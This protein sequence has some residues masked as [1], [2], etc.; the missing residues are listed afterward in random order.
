MPE[1]SPVFGKHRASVC[2]PGTGEEPEP[3][4]SLSGVSRG[5]SGE[6]LLPPVLEGEALGARI[7]SLIKQAQVLQ[8]LLW[9][10][11]LSWMQQ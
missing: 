3:L 11:L 1:K 4:K 7:S 5:T 9:G 8:G 6:L 10:F 2:E